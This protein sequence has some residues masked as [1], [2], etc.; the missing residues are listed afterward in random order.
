MK[1]EDYLLCAESMLALAS[2]R[3]VTSLARIEIILRMTKN[4][5]LLIYAAEA[6]R[7]FG[8]YTSLPVLFEVMKKADLPENL[9]NHMILSATG[10]LG[11]EEWFYPFFTAF[12]EE[13]RNGIDG[14]VDEVT[15][16]RPTGPFRYNQKRFRDA[17]FGIVDDVPLFSSFMSEVFQEAEFTPPS[18]NMLRELFILS[19]K[20]AHLLGHE[21]VRFFFAA[22]FVRHLPR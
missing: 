16:N 11:M 12:L 14:L 7:V 15:K 5:L 9:R 21:T 1:S 13:P 8:E 18:E 3:D 22:V 2:L 20:D 10:I 17:F 4:P 6:V 19:L